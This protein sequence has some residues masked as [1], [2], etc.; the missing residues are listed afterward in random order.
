MITYRLDKVE[1]DGK[2]GFNENEGRKINATRLKTADFLI[3]VALHFFDAS[4]IFNS[5]VD[6]LQAIK[7]SLNV[8][9]R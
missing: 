3:A 4:N 8:P 9:N 1:I 2:K 6:L 5:H 7:F